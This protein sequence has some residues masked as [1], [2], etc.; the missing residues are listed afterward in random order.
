VGQAHIWKRFLIALA[1]LGLVFAVASWIIE[2]V[3]PSQVV[4]PILLV[5]GLIRARKGGAAGVVWLGL[6]AL[7]FLL[8]HIP[9]DKAALSSNCVNPGDSDKPCHPAWWL[10]ELG[11]LPLAMV[12]ASVVAFREV[13]GVWHLPRLRR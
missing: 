2:G 9:F 1:L 11:S 3:T 6:S 10:A 7:V 8:V 12:L 5:L 13:G 4:F